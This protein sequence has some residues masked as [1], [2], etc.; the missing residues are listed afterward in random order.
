MQTAWKIVLNTTEFLVG[1]Q[2]DNVINHLHASGATGGRI[3][4]AVMVD[5]DPGTPPTPDHSLIAQKYHG[6]WEA[7]FPFEALDEPWYRYPTRTRLLHNYTIGAYKPGRHES[8]LP[9][10][11]NIRPDHLAIW[12]YG[13]SPWTP[14]GRARKLQIGK[15]VDAFDRSVGFGHQHIVDEAELDARHAAMLE[16]AKDFEQPLS[17]KARPLKLDP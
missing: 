15:T 12:W 4:G 7:G 8:S 9:N 10:L 17:Y 13:F 3:A 16:F 1:G 11:T 5:S 6:V 14:E 2:L